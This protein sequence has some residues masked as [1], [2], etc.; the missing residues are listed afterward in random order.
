MRIDIGVAAIFLTMAAVAPAW[1]ADLRVM[2]GG[3]PQGALAVLTPMFE[4]ATGNKVHFTFTVLTALQQ[5]LAAGEKI[6]IAIVP[7]PVADK[8]VASGVLLP[9]RRATLGVVSVSMIVREG[10]PR[11]DISTPEAFRQ[12]LLAARSIVYSTP[13]ATPSGAHLAKVIEQLGLADALKA[14]TTYRP[15]LEGGAELVAKGEADIGLYPTSEVVAVKGVSVVGLIPAAVQLRTV[16][17][18]AVAKESAAADAAAAFVKFLSD[19]AH[20]AIWE[21][22]GF[23]TQN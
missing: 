21:K 6:D 2:S 12:A 14:K 18:A 23:E 9:D 1:G 10:A 5:K 13:T 22:A 17:S 15:A 8:L 20:R 19:P 4:Q 16:Y 11:P 3:A 7:I